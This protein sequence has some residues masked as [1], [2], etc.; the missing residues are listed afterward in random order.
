MSC[1]RVAALW[2]VQQHQ[3]WP[4]QWTPPHPL[5][6]QRNL[7]ALQNLLLPRTETWSQMRGVPALAPQHRQTRMVQHLLLLPDASS[8]LCARQL[9][10]R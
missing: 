4:Q 5:L 7:L 2:T 3:T 8:N 10:P 6:R 9:C 1:C